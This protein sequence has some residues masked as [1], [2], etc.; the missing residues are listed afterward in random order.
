VP[1][2]G[3]SVLFLRLSGGFRRSESFAQA[4]SELA[5]AE[6][7]VGGRRLLLIDT[8]GIGGLESCSEEEAATRDL[9]MRAPPDVLV[10]C[11]DA[12]RLV[13]SLALTGQLADLEL[14]LVVGLTMVDEAL[15]RGLVVDA[16]ALSV[17]LGVPV[18][19]VGALD[20]SG[21]RRLQEALSLACRPRQVAYPPAL[22]ARIDGLPSEP[23]RAH[24]VHQVIA[25]P[26]HGLAPGQSIRH[27]AAEAHQHWASELA[28][29]VSRSTGLEPRRTFWDWLASQA[30]HPLRGWLFL[31]LTVALSYLIIAKVG[32]AL[33]AG[34]LE[35]RLATP[36]LRAVGAAIESP[37]WREALVGN[38]GVLSLG[39]LN[40]LCS[41]LPI[42]LVF[43]LLFGLLEEIGY[44]PLLSAQLD[45]L[46]R[47]FGL[48]GRSVLPITLGFGCNS[49]ASLATRTLESRRQRFIACFLISLGIPCAVQLGVVVAVLAAAPAVALL[50][51]VGVI[52]AVQ[53]AA[54]RILALVLPHDEHGEFLV[55]LPPLRAPRPR[56]ILERSGRRLLDFLREAVPLFCASAVILQL[57]EQT[58][59][60]AR[61]RQGL[62]PIVTGG[63]GLPAQYAEMLLTT[64]A[65]REVGAVMLKNLVDQGGLSVK[66][67]VVALTVMTLFVPCLNNTLILG[68]VIGW[69]R[70]LIIFMAVMAIAIGVGVAVNLVWR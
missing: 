45:R 65:R 5:E 3:K 62:A 63:L 30:L 15:A 7:R 8:P 39:L 40:A 22:Q 50:V 60:L 18:V 1:G 9:L 47:S 51:F 56:V 31:L 49:V 19:P 20:G 14:P 32:V 58:G 6:L 21:V 4:S 67:T 11:V 35:Q 16:Q 24:R 70:A 12:G 26:H 48:T 36:I 61:L 42:L 68:R 46:L 53:L 25:G 37:W 69:L 17:A 54:G 13:R 10:Q 55:E 38:F 59:L 43:Y 28:Q 66:Q 33:L 52:T 29:Q 27:M 34:G 41:V 44:F 64:L 23:S 2:S 57:L